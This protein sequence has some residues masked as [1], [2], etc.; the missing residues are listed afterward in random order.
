MVVSERFDILFE[1]MPEEKAL[2][3]LQTNPDDLPN[4]VDKYMAATK[5]AA[6]RSERSLE[7]LIAAVQLDPENLIN[8][9]T[10][11]KALEALGRRKDEKALPSLFS[12]LR[13]DDEP[14]V[15]NALDSIAQI[16]SPLTADQ[17]DQLLEAL[18]S[19]DT[20]SYTHLTLPT[21]P[22]V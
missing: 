13:F 19:S 18:Q 22:Y 3:L 14:S 15:I 11:R 7:G 20:V 5:L 12:A 6:C 21:T 10:R 2:L 17:S 8:R 9:I 4:P 1:G 16:G